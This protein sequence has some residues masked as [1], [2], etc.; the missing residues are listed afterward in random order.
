MRCL[1]K[2]KFVLYF[3]CSFL[4]VL[5]TNAEEV[6][7]NRL[8]KNL[9]FCCG[10]CHS[11]STFLLPRKLKNLKHG[12]HWPSIPSFVL[13]GYEEEVT[14]VSIMKNRSSRDPT[15]HPKNDARETYL[16]VCTMRTLQ[17][18]MTPGKQRNTR[19]NGREFT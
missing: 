18:R 8:K 7:S 5:T 4:L 13:L 9:I 3:I 12:K 16:I 11:L 19:G 6:N 17:A 15:P 14:A 10:F 2:I 1:S